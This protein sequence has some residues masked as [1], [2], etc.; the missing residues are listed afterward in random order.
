MLRTPD[1]S[2][3]FGRFRSKSAHAHR[4]GVSGSDAGGDRAPAPLRQREALRRR[5]THVRGR[6]AARRHVRHAQGPGRGLAARRPRPC[7]ADSEQGPGQFLAEVG[8]L[9]ARPSF[10]DGHAKGEVEA[11]LIPPDG[12][13]ALLIAEAELGERI[14][15]ALIL[16][17]VSLIDSDSGGVVLIGPAD[18]A[19]RPAAAEFPR[20]ATACRI[21]CSIPRPIRRR[22][23]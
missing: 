11:L 3:D 9:S 2:R 19:G 15:R 22:R 12:L 6:Q 17:R 21:T 16:R 18:D 8:T 5:R 20:R 4:P 10:V 1:V 13:R 14:M 7:H 23:S